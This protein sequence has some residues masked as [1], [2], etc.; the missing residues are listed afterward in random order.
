MAR[1]P[2]WNKKFN[3]DGT[4][5]VIFSS[6]KYFSDYINQE[7]LNYTNYIYRGHG[8]SKWK[9]EPTLDRIIK[10]PTSQ[11]RQEHLE[12]FIY[13]TRG[14]RGSNPPVMENEND[15]WALG[16]H[17]GLYTPLLDWTES[18]FVALFFA[19]ESLL[20][21]KSTHCSVH[22]IAQSGIKLI[23]AKIEEDESEVQKKIDQLNTIYRN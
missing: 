23:N 3:G 11:K 13:S 15:W 18:P 5:E 2:R 8:D 14:R 20:S 12:E 19:I 9:L 7:M 21:K 4:C 16:Q 1:T 17:H 22:A 6:W 10:H